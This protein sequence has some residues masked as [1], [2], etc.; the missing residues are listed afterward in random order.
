MFAIAPLSF[1][2]LFHRQPPPLPNPFPPS[3]HSGR[4]KG[5]SDWRGGRVADQAR[6]P[7]EHA[8]SRG[9]AVVLRVHAK[10]HRRQREATGAVAAVGPWAAWARRIG[11][12]L[13]L[14]LA[15]GVFDWCPLHPF[16][17]CRRSSPRGSWSCS[18]YSG[19]IWSAA[20][21]CLQEKCPTHLRCATRLRRCVPGPA[22][23]QRRARFPKPPPTSLKPPY[24]FAIPGGRKAV[25]SAGAGQRGGGGAFGGARCSRDSV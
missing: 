11:A 2:F 19:R 5:Q 7:R 16:L 4:K 9:R 12:P 14:H 18:R 6:R 15:R 8:A 17:C 20:C 1:I 22:F 10:K 23:F 21:R 24:T 25:A 13:R 3:P